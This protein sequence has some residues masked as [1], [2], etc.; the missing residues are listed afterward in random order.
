MKP[1]DTSR[2]GEFSWNELMTTDHH[3]AFAF[4]AEVFGW[5]KLQSMDMGPM[6]TYE[7]F[8]K[9][10]KQLGGMFRK[11]ADAPASGVKDELIAMGVDAASLEG[12]S[13]ADMQAMLDQMKSQG[14]PP[15]MMGEVKK[16]AEKL[17]SEV[18]AELAKLI[19]Q[20]KTG[21]GEVKKYSEDAAKTARETAVDA[22]L[23]AMADE[24]RIFPAQIPMWRD[25]LTEADDRTVR[26]FAENGKDYSET[27]YAR[28]VRHLKGQPRVVSFAEKVAASTFTETSDAEV[29]KVQ[30]FA[31]DNAGSLKAGGYTPASY[32]A[33][34]AEMR[35]KKPGLTAAEYGVKG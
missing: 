17:F 2:P 34:F 21:A 18:K 27:A 31:E 14:A 12:M 3:A 11:P 35:K 1:H 25:E 15:A 26:K 29:N 20:A 19:T 16:Y 33:G 10:G 24:G 30:R 32:V 5:Q 22:L 8:G 6:G 4:Y 28:K 13:D 7:L 9:D 23:K